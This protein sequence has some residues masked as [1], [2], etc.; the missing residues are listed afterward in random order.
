MRNYRWRICALLF[1]ATTINYI[2]RQVLGLLAPL[3]QSNIG[4]NEIQYGYIVTAFQAAYALGL[5]TMGSIVDRI[6]TKLGYALAISIWSLSAMGHALVQSALGFG[7]ARF[8][9]GFGE[10]GSFPAAIK[11]VAEWFPKK[12]R[13][14][15]TGLFN[16]GTNVGATLAPLAV[17][18]VAVHYGWRY[19]FLLT[20]TFSAI[21]LAAWLMFYRLPQDHPRISKAELEYILS[22]PPEP[23]AKVQW[24]QLL[25][26]PQTWAF[27]LGKS[28]IDPIWWFYLFWLPK[29]LVTEHHLTLTGVALPIVVVYNSA[30]AGSVVGGWLPA[31]FLS[32]GWTVN[33][34]RKVSLLICALCVTPVV[35]ATRVHALWEAVALI[36][37]ACA[38]HQGFSANLFTLA[39]DMFPRRAVAS[40]VGIGG[41]GGAVGGMFI[42]TFTGWLLQ[43]TGSYL[44]IFVLAGSV[45]VVALGLIQILAPRLLP[46]ELV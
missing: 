29:F 5:L 2:D 6:G 4:F 9:L 38:A 41:C 46:A 30:T 27:L 15:A 34:A 37:L 42:A 26:Y 31:K 21:W 7:V 40:V 36:S 25:G 39:S 32:L 20:G 35:I 1:F 22:D 10:S 17:P 33:R 28:L 24:S 12:E 14:L 45:Y 19:A 16:S 8:A 11:A 23:T 18:W 43:L 13:A 44:P 3:L